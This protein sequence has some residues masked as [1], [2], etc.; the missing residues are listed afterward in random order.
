MTIT[1]IARQR[2]H[3]LYFLDRIRSF[4]PV[5]LD[6]EVDMTQVTAHRAEMSGR[7]TRYSFISYVLYAV[8]HALR[9]HPEANAAIRGH[10][11]PRVA[12]Y[13]RVAVKLTMDSELD[14]HRIVLTAILPDADQA[15]LDDIQRMVNRYRNGDAVHLPEFA[16]VRL[17]H[18]IPWP[19][20][21][22]LFHVAS[23]PLSR[24]PSTLGT[25]A[26]T[27]LG[28]RPVDGFYSVGGTTVTIG[29]G[30]V[31]DRPVARGGQVTIAPFM[32]LSLTFD[33]R[34][35]DGAEAADVLADI[36][37]ALEKFDTDA[38]RKAITNH[39]ERR[40]GAEE[41]WPDARAGAE[42]QR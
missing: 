21:P 31:T 1:P 18:R 5:F 11:W 26:V 32:R 19:I 20:G 12:R 25:V 16:R 13:D 3:T 7:G 24:R 41:V 29:V 28:H 36:K 4:A 15:S 17:L 8:G 2:R 39:D 34:V 23:S 37:S 35:I 38:S 6:C 14:G 10:A 33:H 42:N 27:S 40:R 30:Q 9:A 22:I